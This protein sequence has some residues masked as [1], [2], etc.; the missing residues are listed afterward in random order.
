MP[1]EVFHCYEA[2]LIKDLGDYTLMP[3]WLAEGAGEW[4]QATLT[5]HA[6]TPADSQG[7]GGSWRRCLT[8]PE[9]SLYT[10]SYD[11]I[12]F[13]S[14]MDKKGFPPWSRFGTMFLSW[15]S[16]GNDG[17]FQAG[18]VDESFFDPWS[19]SYVRQPS[20]GSDWDITGPA[21]SSD[22]FGVPQVTIANGD[23]TSAILPPVSNDAARLDLSAEVVIFVTPDFAR[24]QSP[25]SGLDPGPPQGAWCVGASM[26]DCPMDSPHAGEHLPSLPADQYYLAVNGGMNG[27]QWSVIG[28][29]L[30][31]YCQSTGVDPCLQGGLVEQ[32][33]AG[34]P[35]CNFIE[36][37]GPVLSIHNN[38]S[39]VEDYSG[40]TD[41]VTCVGP[42]DAAL[43]GSSTAKMIAQ[44]GMFQLSNIDTS[45]MVFD[46]AAGSVGL[47]TFV[48]LGNDSG[49]GII[50]GTYACSSS[51]AG[52]QLPDGTTF[53]YSR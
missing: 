31:T 45:G 40:F 18:V 15:V 21:I 13:Y 5:G 11:G 49:T 39:V 9:I 12:C 43:S 25:G 53:Y 42:V 2:S 37:L 8:H 17:A 38:G 47:Q 52:I 1:H 16:G 10:L 32:T 41:S 50:R 30:D 48:L 6:V 24:L 7:P 29:S 44:H 35:G 19:R 26:C 4:V 27:F 46:G 22:R 51:T 14:E 28:Q 34:R 3:S 33:V 23:S 36:P 20:L